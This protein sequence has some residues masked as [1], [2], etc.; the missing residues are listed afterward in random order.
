M[1]L[2]PYCPW[3]LCCAPITEILEKTEVNI[4]GILFYLKLIIFL[5]I[6]CYSDCICGDTFWEIPAALQLLEGE[7][8]FLSLLTL[9]GWGVRENTNLAKLLCWTAFQVIVF[10]QIYA[11]V[12]LCTCLGGRE[13]FSLFLHHQNQELEDSVGKLAPWRGPPCWKWF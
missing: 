9:V 12:E 1:H 11:H 6:L 10:S 2:G 4:F 13:A 3:T 7:E 5:Y 8:I